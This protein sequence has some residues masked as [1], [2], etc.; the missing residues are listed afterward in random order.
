M[1]GPFCLVIVRTGRDRFKLYLEGYADGASPSRHPIPRY[2]SIASQP[3]EG[4]R[5]EEAAHAHFLDL[6]SEARRQ[7]Y[8]REETAARLR[9]GL[10]IPERRVLRSRQLVR[11]LRRGAAALAAEPVGH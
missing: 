5:S 4:F 3:R 8:E 7:G 1:R 2:S 9:R 11:R 6:L 10:R